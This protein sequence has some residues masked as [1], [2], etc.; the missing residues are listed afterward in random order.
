[1]INDISGNSYDEAL[2]EYKIIRKIKSML[3]S[4]VGL[5]DSIRSV[6]D[7][8]KWSLGMFWF[9]LVR[10]F[11]LEVILGTGLYFLDLYTDLQFT[12]Y[13]FGQSERNFTA[14]ISECTPKFHARFELTKNYCEEGANFDPNAC[15]EMVRNIKLMADYCFVHDNRFEESSE[16][17]IV[18]IMSACHCALPIL[19]S[20]ITWMFS[21]NWRLCDRRSLLTFPL[22]F[23]TKMY[24]FH[25]T[26]KHFKTY[27]KDRRGEEDRSKFELN[28]GKWMNKIRNHE[29]VV[30]LSLLIEASIESS[31]QFWFQT[32]FLIPTVIITI[33]D[34]LVNWT[35]LFSWRLASI[36][37]SF[38][39]FAYAFYNIR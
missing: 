9:M 34:G 29:A 7:R 21:S 22:P 20:I 33:T 25:Y 23:V 6:R 2:E 36:C 14:E 26:R 8:F 28:R 15:L 24:Q 39:T 17:R 30:N 37:I 13:L 31:F 27:T 16:W 18:G 38:G 19:V 12:F 5:R 3:P 32:T 11:I 10:S 35:D 4:S 1:M